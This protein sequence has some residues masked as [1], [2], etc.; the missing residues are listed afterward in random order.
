MAGSR[1]ALDLAAW[2]D[3]DHGG[4][5]P[6]LDRGQERAVLAAFLEVCYEQ[7]GKAPHLLDGQELRELLVAV[8][9]GRFGRRDPSVPHVP[10]LL[11][12]YLDH[13]EETQTVSDAFELRAALD[14]TGERFVAAVRSGAVSHEQVPA[15]KPILNRAPKLGRND[16]CWCGSGRKFKKCHGAAGGEG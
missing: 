11:G 5:S 12:R 6:D 4:R 9:P 2:F 13:L 15:V 16:P 8:L 10:A 3:G 1:I 14:A 7:M